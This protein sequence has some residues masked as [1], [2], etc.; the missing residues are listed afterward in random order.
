MRLWP[1]L[2]LP[3]YL[4]GQ[5]LADNSI[6]IMNQQEECIKIKNRTPERISNLLLLKLE[7]KILKSTGY[8]GC[9]SALNSYKVRENPI[10]D[11]IPLW[12]GWG[13]FSVSEITTTVI[14]PVTAIAD[15]SDYHLLITCAKPD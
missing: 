3:L 7:F 14:L 9:K 11:N 4:S 10:K 15:N 5:A 13:K 8:C 6:S 12:H 1:V 2:F